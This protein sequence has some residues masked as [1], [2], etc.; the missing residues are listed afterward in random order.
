MNRYTICCTAEQT[1]K[2]LELG[3]P[4]QYAS[5]NDIRLE[6]YVCIDDECYTIPTTDQMIWWLRSKGIQFHFDDETN[7]WNIGDATNDLTPLRRYGYSDNKELSAIDAALEYLE[8]NK[9]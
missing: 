9:Q 1:K 2:A 3:A 5:I 8:N 4:I 7:Y 6:R